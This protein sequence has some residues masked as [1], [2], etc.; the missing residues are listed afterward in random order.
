MARVRRARPPR[1]FPDSRAAPIFGCPK[2]RPAKYAPM[3]AAMTMSTS[4]S[5]MCGPRAKPGVA[6]CSLASAMKAGT[7]TGTPQSSASAATMPRGDR[8]P[9]RSN[10]ISHQAQA[11]LSSSRQMRRLRGPSPSQE[12]QQRDAGRISGARRRRAQRAETGPFPG[13]DG[14]HRAERQHRPG[15]R[16]QKQA[17]QQQSADQNGRRHYSGSKHAAPHASAFAATCAEV[18]PKRR[19]RCMKIFEGRLQMRRGEFR[20]ERV[21]EDKAPCRQDSTAGNC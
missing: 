19:S 21:G 16:Q 6:I 12:Q 7:S 4:H 10:A 5:T 8:A 17:Q 11:A 9:A 15:R 2:A 13:A 3:S 1:S 14:E 18:L 20:P